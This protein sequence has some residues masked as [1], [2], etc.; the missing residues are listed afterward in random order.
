MDRIDLAPTLTLSRILYG[1]WR[2]HEDDTAPARVREKLDAC[3][4]AGITAIDLADIYGGYTTEAVLGVAFGEDSGLRDRLEIVTKCGI[5]AP[6]GRHAG[7]RVK[8]YDTSAEHLRASVDASLAALRTD[9]IDLLLLHRPDPFMDA[10]AT[11]A[12][13]DALVAAGKVRHLGVSNFLPHDT[14]LLQSALSAPLV[15]NQIELSLLHSAPFR[16]GQIADLQTR[17]MTPMAWSP[18]AGGRILGAD[19]QLAERLAA[20]ASDHDCDTA[21]VAI[22]WLLAHPATVLPVL[23]TNAPARIARLGAA[24]EVS[25]TREE[26]FDLYT[27]ALGAEVP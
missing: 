17:R 23:G 20:V 24:C 16:D 15:A 11:G 12:A 8:H 22:A 2:L 5:V 9:R 3:L 10:E 25:L 18:L 6:Q 1:T 21:T 4:S 19:G 7:V 27:A 26:W 14:A 13:L